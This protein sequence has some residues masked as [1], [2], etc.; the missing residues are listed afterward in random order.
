[1]KWQIFWIVLAV[2]C[3]I[4]GLLILR[5]A[6][7]TRFFAV[8]FAMTAVFVFFCIAA[9]YHL[10]S[11]LPAAVKAVLLV[12]IVGC[13]TLFVF[14]EAKILGGFSEK[15]GAELD[16]LLVLGAQVRASGPSRVLQYRLDAARDYL[17]KN[18]NTI[19]IVSGGRGKN[20]PC[21]EAE[22][23]RRYLIEKGI[24]SERIL[25]ETESRNTKENMDYSKTL[26]DPA[27]DSVGIV[28]NNFHMYRAKRLAKKAGIR[29][30]SAVTA[31]STP[32]YLPN[33]LLRE[34][35][36]VVKDHMAGNI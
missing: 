3:A 29:R 31:G 4:Y 19:C 30:L 26:F 17:E 18:E 2:L 20:E 24:P 1:M 27:A 8:W 32:L 33:N 21:T 23:M 36:G 13:L 22:G 5:A 35:M 11:S 16:C 25:T 28:T 9:R 6:S 7:G 12:I 10:W 14:V 15:A 34:F